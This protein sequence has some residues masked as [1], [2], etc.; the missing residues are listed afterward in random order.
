M[1]N[2]QNKIT[3][4]W[5]VPEYRQHERSRRWYIIALATFALLM[6]YSF[7]TANF[8]FALILIIAGIIIV[9]Q[10]K[11]QPPS[12]DFAI[13]ED[14][15]A[16]GRDF[17]DY[18]KL[19]SFWIFYEP[20]EAKTLFFEFKNKIRPRLGVPLFDK[21]PLHVRSEL[22]KFLTE[23]VSRENEPVSEQLSRLLKL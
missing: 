6:L 17:Y 22:L 10:D 19:Q 9:L 18:S 3:I 15:I 20:D 21:N 23:D 4:E 8:L 16:L 11:H 12:I 5:P 14:G 1:P 2:N 13:T 7:F